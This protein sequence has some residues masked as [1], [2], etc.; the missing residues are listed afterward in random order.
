[1]SDDFLNISSRLNQD[2]N[3]SNV[4]QQNAS[5]TNSNYNSIGRTSAPNG[6]HIP[7]SPSRSV[8]GNINSFGHFASSYTRAQSFLAIEPPKELT[9]PRAFFVDDEEALGTS[10][11]PPFGSASHTHDNQQQ[12]YPIPSS[13]QPSSYHPVGS[14]SSTAHSFFSNRRP[15][16]SARF[17]DDTV[18]VNNAQLALNNQGSAVYEDFDDGASEVSALIPHKASQIFS[19]R[20]ASSYLVPP[21][22]GTT[23]LQEGEAVAPGTETEPVIVRTIEDKDGN[24]ST[25]VAGQSTVPQ[26]IFNS[27]NLLIGIGLL[28]LPLGFKYSGWAIGLVLLTFSAL[29]THYTALLLARCMNTD[30]TLVTYADIAYAAYGPKARI[31]TSMLF[32]FELLGMGVSLVILFAD[33]LNALF[34]Q[35]D[36]NTYKYI[37]F[38]VLSPPCFLPLR[39]LSISSILGIISTLGLIVIVFFDGLYKPE[40][41]GSLWSPEKTHLFPTNWMAVPLSIGIFMAPWG[42]HAVFPNIYRDMRHP[43]K[44]EGALKQVYKITYGVDL[45]MGVLGF[46]MFGKTVDNEVTKSILLTPGYP[47]H[48]GIIITSLISLIP[49]AKTPLNARPIVTTVDALSG[50][51]DVPMSFDGLFG[52]KIS[53]KSFFLRVAKACVRLGVVL[54]FVYLSIVFPDFD[55]IIAFFGASLCI[56]ICIAGPIAFYLK[57]YGDEVPKWEKWLN[58]VL[59][60]IYFI[61]A[62]V[63]TVWCFI[64]PE[65]LVSPSN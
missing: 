65:Q 43:Q 50:L 23:L 49:L 45:A 27:V 47:E 10:P 60:A 54:A 15:S 57:I 29:S 39:I 20:R 9:R 24:I 38:L 31:L 8:S 22:S 18:S 59:F 28:S 16:F 30:P 3:S 63:G 42:G 40:A 36:K 37:A 5:T 2:A 51:N 33:S 46:L 19:R 7:S 12:Q 62:V 14:V 48:Q 26:T 4:G 56:T 55:R 1:M 13:H 25:E 53:P 21:Q 6:I 11:V 41:P 17:L 58:Y 34:P 61:M 52:G 44:Y 32:T 64:P 35:I